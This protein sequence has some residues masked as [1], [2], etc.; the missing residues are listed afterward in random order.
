[1]ARSTSIAVIGD[2]QSQAIAAALEL[3]LPGWT[4]SSSFAQRATKSRPDPDVYVRECAAVLVQ[5]P[6]LQAVT[7][8]A[9]V[10]GSQPMIL[11]FPEV[12]FSGFHPDMLSAGDAYRGTAPFLSSLGRSHSAICLFGWRQGY[13]IDQVLGLFNGDVYA[14]LGYHDEQDLARARLL[15]AGESCG[16]DLAAAYAKWMQ[17]DCFMHCVN[18]PKPMVIAEIARQLVARLGLEPAVRFPERHMRDRFQKM[19]VWAFYPEVAQAMGKQGEYVFSN[20]VPIKTQ[21]GDKSVFGLEDM[22][23]SSYQEYDRQG[24]GA[25]AVARFDDPRYAGLGAFLKKPALARTA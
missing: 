8:A 12:H 18:H 13:S 5:H 22:V 10:A 14:H 15:R 7:E 2:C 16:M 9:R 19:L 25:V 6:M 1:M 4:I 3:M 24:R 11:P 17:G 20:S 23:W 21:A